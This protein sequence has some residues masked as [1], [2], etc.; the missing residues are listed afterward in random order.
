MLPFASSVSGTI[1]GFVIHE[2]DASGSSGGTMT[3]S[4]DSGTGVTEALLPAPVTKRAIQL[5]P[6]EISV[7][8][9][10]SISKPL[11]VRFFTVQSL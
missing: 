1:S 7:S 11:R 6:S 3:S 2:E 9:A 8:V 10:T 4:G 5:N